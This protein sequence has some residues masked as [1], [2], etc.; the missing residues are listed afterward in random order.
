MIQFSNQETSFVLK[1][2]LKIQDWVRNILIE[3]GKQTGEITYIYCTDDYLLQLNIHYLN[4]HTL[5]DI[6]TFDYSENAKISG[7][8]FISV[9]RIRENAETFSKSFNEELGRV[10][11]HGVLHLVGYKDKSEEDK[12]RM[13][14]KEN[15]YLA[16]F[17]NL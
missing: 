7:D 16:Q 1:N 2:K 11:A 4:H 12:T 8:I 9:E 15:Q 3:E 5:T 14:E 17:P 6:I 10:M 13:T